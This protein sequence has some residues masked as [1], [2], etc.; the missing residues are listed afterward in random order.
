MA[1]SKLSK[2]DRKVLAKATAKGPR[3][4]VR[5]KLDESA[6][7][8]EDGADKILREA[9]TAISQRRDVD[10]VLGR[11]FEAVLSLGEARGFRNASYDLL[12]DGV[13]F[14]EAKS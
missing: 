5:A 14:F 3:D 2:R 11:V 7:D 10:E 8:A 1:F 12:E 6:K 13:D 9:A 4:R